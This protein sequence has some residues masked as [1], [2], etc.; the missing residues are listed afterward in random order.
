MVIDGDRVVDKADKGSL[1]PHGSYVL[2]TDAVAD[3]RVPGRS[4]GRSVPVIVAA[5][6]KSESSAG[7]AESSCF[8]KL[9]GLLTQ[10]FVT[11]LQEAE[12]CPS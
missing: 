10:K 12:D 6:M 4:S 5:M 11:L 8:Q 9:L 1:W 3:I 7:G 2:D